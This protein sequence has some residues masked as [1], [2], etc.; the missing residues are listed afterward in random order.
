MTFGPLP[1]VSRLRR[2][3]SLLEEGDP[4][5]TWLGERLR[6]WLEGDPDGGSLE[7]ALGLTPGWRQAKRLA[8]RDGLIRALAGT[9]EGPPTGRAH[10]LA[11][12]LRRYARA[13]WHHD[14]RRGQPTAEER[15]RQ[16]LF[17]LFSRDPD[18]PL[19]V[20]RL[21][22]IITAP[23]AVGSPCSLHAE[24]PMLAQV[25]ESDGDAHG[26]PRTASR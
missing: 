20:R 19:S 3:A 26:F 15:Q 2:V 25:T 17:D 4:D 12:L 24:P 10:A 14:R 13:G 21:Y 8:E 16:L 18:P 22:D 23:D 9:L 1:A 5:Q 11:M 6:A 7:A